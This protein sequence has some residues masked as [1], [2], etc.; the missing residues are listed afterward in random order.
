MYTTQALNALKS[1]IANVVTGRLVGEATEKL[2]KDKDFLQRFTVA[3]ASKWVES[4]PIT[5]SSQEADELK[6]YFAAQAKGLLEKGVTIEKVNNTDTLFTIAPAD[7]SYKVNFGK[8][9][10]E[11]YFKAFLR[12]LLVD[13]LF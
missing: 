9:E 3:L 2:A 1:E 5:I 4:E 7:G 12:P 6:A 11:N 8:E 13:M 10:F